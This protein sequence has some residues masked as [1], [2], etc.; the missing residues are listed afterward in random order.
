[1]ICCLSVK[2]PR[3]LTRRAEWLEQLATL[4][5]AGV[6]ILRA[7]ELQKRST[8]A[9]PW[10]K[11]ITTLMGRIEA[12]DPLPVALAQSG[13]WLSD[14]DQTLLGAAAQSG[15]M[16]RALRF[17]AHDDRERAKLQRLM[18]SG[19]LYPL[20]MAHLAL[21]VFPVP[22]LVDAVINGLPAPY[23]F[24]KAQVFSGLYGAVFLGYLALWLLGER[25]RALAEK[26]AGL[27]PGVGASRRCWALSRTAAALDG[28]L[29]AGVPVRQA[30]S[31]SAAASGSPRLQRAVRRWQGDW[32]RGGLPSESLHRHRLFR[33][34][35]ADL[36]ATG[37]LSGSLDDALPRIQAYYEEETRR[38]LRV[39]A[40][41]VPSII[42][43]AVVIAVAYYVLSFYAGYYR[44]LDFSF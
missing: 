40:A 13:N 18:M 42:Y 24:A 19:L 3:T 1:M 22:L 28:L 6:P 5:E 39:V 10:R 38:Y 34:V 27:V 7:L 35:F 21:L 25:F 14:F 29:A 26:L 8:L 23:L 2:S 32:E 20:I 37:E 15:R 43:A 9:R 11:G 17:L 30:W 44:Q 16:E 12:G 41:V 33:G 4:L 31:M 36:Y